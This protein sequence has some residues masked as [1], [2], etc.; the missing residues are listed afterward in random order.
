MVSSLTLTP[1]K[2][3]LIATDTWKTQRKWVHAAMAASHQSHFNGHIENEVKRW[4]VTLLVDPGQFHANT[5][6]LTGRII[7]TLAWDDAGQGRAY[8]ESALATLKQ[9]SISGPVVNALTPLWHLADLVRHNP[10]RTY[11]VGREAAQRAWWARSL[12]ASKARFLRGDLPA[13]T[14][15]YRYCAQLAA[16]ENATLEQD[17]SEE[18][19]AACMLGFQCLVGVIT[20]SGPMQFFLMAMALHPEWLARCQE[21]LDRVCGDRMPTVADAP[22]LPTVRACLKE[23]L[24]WRPGVPLG[25]LTKSCLAGVRR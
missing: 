10:W 18:D 8:G 1:F 23:T 15:A 17:N 13:D 25:K 7:N 21:E 19:F 2:D 5:R 4:L 9:M 3:L 20:L 24:R 6:E 11:E 14:W 12:R 22:H 16:G